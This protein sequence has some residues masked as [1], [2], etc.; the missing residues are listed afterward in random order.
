M[1]QPLNNARHNAVSQADFGLHKGQTYSPDIDDRAPLSLLTFG[2]A[3]SDQYSNC[4]PAVTTNFSTCPG[5]S[6][7]YSACA[8]G[9]SITWG[10]S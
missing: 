8:S 6:T 4:G 5:V 7:S 3:I 2:L 10:L 1:G 9:T